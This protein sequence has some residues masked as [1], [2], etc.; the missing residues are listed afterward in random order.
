MKKTPFHCL[1]DPALRRALGAGF[2]AM[3]TSALVGCV[4]D[5]PD[6]LLGAPAAESPG[7]AHFAGIEPDLFKSCG[8]CH[9]A[10]G[11]ADTPFLRGPDRYKSMVSWPGFV[12]KDPA[13]SKL[14][15]YPVGG[16]SHMGSNLDDGSGD[17][18]M[19][20]RVRAWIEEEAK[21]LNGEAVQSASATTPRAPIDGFN[22]VYLED[23]GP[24]FKSMAITFI[25]GELSPS[26]LELTA[27]EVHPSSKSGLRIAHP[28]FV[29]HS[30]GAGADP[31]PIDSFSNV[32]RTFP[33]G[34]SGQLPPGSLL[35][36][37]WAPD[38]KLSIAFEIIEEL[39]GSPGGVA[40]G[41]KAVDA[42][43]ASAEPLFN[44]YCSTCHGGGDAGAQAAVDMSGL[45]KDSA[46]A[47]GQILNRVSLETPEKSQVFLMTDPASGAAHKFKFGQDEGAFKAFKEAVSAWIQAEQ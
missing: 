15:T 25:A 18:G 12:V 32:D 8:G 44:A 6:S 1:Q 38:A 19:L 5:L 16:T 14:L 2:F 26:M 31:D 22:S 13:S 30:V 11:L 17:G 3:V 29:V 20:P 35:L 39:A 4:G 9:D 43:K 10:G 28:L 23:F 40:K 24:P 37:N 34:A 47:C 33:K 27:I 46:A 7:R 45:M 36:P 41:C 42:F 21:A